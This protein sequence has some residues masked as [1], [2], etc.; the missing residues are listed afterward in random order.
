LAK[1]KIQT[2]FDNFETYKNKTDKALVEELSLFERFTESIMNRAKDHHQ[3]TLNNLEETRESIAGLKDKVEELKHNI[4]YHKETLIIDRQKIIN[5]TEKSI[6]VQ[7]QNILEFE[8]KNIQDKVAN[9]D[10]LNKAL[11]QSSF[12]FFAEFKLYYAKDIMDFEELY[13]F[14]EEKNLVFQ[15]I[16]QKYESEIMSSFNTLDNEILDM[17]DRIA[18]LMQQKNSQLNKIYDF[19]QKETSSYIDNQLSFS[20]ELDLS[21]EEIKNLIDDK[22]KQFRT[23]KNHLLNQE[24][25]IRK[26]LHE[27]YVDLYDKVLQKILQRRAHFFFGD[28]DFFDHVETSTTKIKEQI[29]YAKNE[30][31]DNLGTLI[32]RLKRAKKHQKIK[33]NAEK[34]AR[35][36]T[37]KFLK[38]KKGI[39]F[40]YQKESRMLIN[41]MDKYYKLYLDILKVDPFLAQIIGD[42]ATKIVKDEVNYLTTL[43]INKE[44]KINVNY[45]IKTLRINQQINEIESKLIYEVERQL[46]LQDIDLLS[47]IMDVQNF[48]IDKIADTAISK[49]HMMQEKNQIF[50]LEK[51]IASYLK[52]ELSINNINRRYHSLVTKLMT[53]FIRNIE[54]HNIKVVDALSDIKLALKE[55]DIAAIH[56]KTLFE[57]EKRFLV[58]QS[59]RVDQENKI[60]NEFI[61]T[62]LKN[63]M[64]FAEEQISLANDEFR[65]RGQAIITAVDEEREYY[66]DIIDNQE[67]SAKV[68]KQDYLDEYQAKIYKY[69]T[70]LLEVTDKKELKKLEKDYSK[71]K[72]KYQALIAKSE[73]TIIENEITADARRRLH[74]LDDHLQE[75]LEEAAK[76]RDDTIEEMQEIYNNAKARYDYLKVYLENK[77]NPLEP[78]FYQQLE[79]SKKRYE[80][81]LKIAETELDL[82]TKSLLENYLQ[83]YFEDKPEVDKIKIIEFIEGLE[84]EKN[85]ALTEYQTTIENIESEYQNQ[86]ASLNQDKGNIIEKLKI[87][88]QKILDQKKVEISKKT[89]QLHLMENKYMNQQEQKKHSFENEISN[90][91]N[92]YNT[93]LQQSK[94]YISNLSQ[95]FNKVLNTY[96]PYV[97]LTKNNRKIRHIIKKTNHNIKLKEKRELRTLERS[98]RKHKLLIN[99]D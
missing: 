55:Y 97:K 96:K 37:N 53:D 42:N 67:R 73:M 71:V 81:K 79:S 15:K 19:Y 60:N 59:T 1:N 68:R 29:V 82:K 27:E 51:A 80:R 28:S 49:N 47:A 43:K 40:E 50:R 77:V 22:I 99:E 41:E 33:A 65:M 75:A 5:E 17:N 66:Q 56:F 26:I 95:A 6:Q 87:T 30:N 76:L 31:K 70:D 23:F 18:L 10:Y 24:S 61:L 16:I 25:K 11:L 48:F 93:T 57:N 84:T 44:H 12:D 3:V 39:F 38:M 90:L 9:Y 62:T 54:G 72:E 64:R 7:N 46:Y 92:E 86:I 89:Q 2:N 88:K 45:D 20:A 63:R 35:R 36:M 14:F 74:Q 85:L 98:L 69:Q 34:R 4:F 21:S 13:K 78:T 8:Y 94:K 91:T 83:V 32:R 58:M 52:Y